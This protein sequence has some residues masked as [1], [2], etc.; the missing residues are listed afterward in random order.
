M[1]TLYSQ[2]T[3]LGSA[4]A[5]WC[6]IIL[7]SGL[8][9]GSSHS[10]LGIYSSS[11]P[12]SC[13]YVSASCSRI[14]AS[15]RSPTASGARQMAP[16]L[17]ASTHPS[18]H[19]SPHSVSPRMLSSYLLSTLDR[20]NTDAVLGPSYPPFGLFVYSLLS[21]IIDQYLVFGGWCHG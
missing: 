18:P 15:R 13:S 16:S 12:P 20:S 7:F 4:N 21:S 6:S 10:I 11:F 14:S 8:C 17:L 5:V 2:F 1:L 9:C 19:S 3:S